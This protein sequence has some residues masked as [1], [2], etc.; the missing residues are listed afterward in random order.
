[1]IGSY[2]QL[3]SLYA[4]EAVEKPGRITLGALVHRPRMTRK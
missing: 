3:F 1:M 2:P 4:S